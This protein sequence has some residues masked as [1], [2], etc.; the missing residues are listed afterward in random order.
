VQ[1]SSS[2]STSS[3]RCPAELHG[4]EGGGCCMQ[5]STARAEPHV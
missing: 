2:S 5:H 4:V 3:S 1:C